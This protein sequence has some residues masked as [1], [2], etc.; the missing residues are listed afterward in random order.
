M[1]DVISAWQMFARLNEPFPAFVMQWLSS[2]SGMIIVGFERFSGRMKFL[3]EGY[4]SRKQGSLTFNP[5]RNGMKFALDVNGRPRK[6]FLIWA[7]QK[8]TSSASGMTRLLMVL[9]I[10]ENSTTLSHSP[11]PPSLSYLTPF[12][13]PR[14]FLSDPR[15]I[16][17]L[18]HH[19]LQQVHTR[20]KPF[21][22]SV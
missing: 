1:G 7:T 10:I 3:D 14:L 17:L 20:R 12:P 18:I 13:L 19:R 15:L 16:S 2:A 5:G 8:L 22:H 11:P 4:I 6:R 9:N 21:S